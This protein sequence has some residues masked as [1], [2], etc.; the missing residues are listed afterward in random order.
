MSI[1]FPQ[2][3]ATTVETG[4]WKI[5][6][7]VDM[8]GDSMDTGYIGSKSIM[9]TFSNS[10]TTNAKLKVRFRIDKERISIQLFEYGGNHPVKDGMEDGYEIYVKHNGEMLYIKNEKGEAIQLLHARHYGDYVTFKTPSAK[11][12]MEKLKEGGSFKFVLKPFNYSISLYR[13]YKFSIPDADGFLS[14]YNSLF[15]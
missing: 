10:A 13:D 6:Y 3:K 5:N 12:L 9:G 15:Q 1:I 4:I 8:F 7:Y 14:V 2:V 11:I